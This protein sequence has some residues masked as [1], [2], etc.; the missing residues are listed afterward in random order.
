MNDLKIFARGGADK[1]RGL[2]V[3]APRCGI[4]L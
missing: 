3:I 2:E 1:P 4:L